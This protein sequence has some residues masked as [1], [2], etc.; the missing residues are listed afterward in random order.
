MHSNTVMKASG[1]IWKIYITTVGIWIGISL[2][3]IGILGNIYY[4][5]IGL[6]L[7][8]F[9]IAYCCLAIRCPECG[10]HW[11]WQAIKRGMKFGWLKRLIYQSEC[12]SC[13]YGGTD[14]A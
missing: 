14:A 13:G 9:S 3:I 12:Q 7:G 4:V 1:Q 5:P 2:S 8:L 6:V 10:Q 11:Y